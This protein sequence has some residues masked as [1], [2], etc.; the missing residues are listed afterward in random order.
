MNDKGGVAFVVMGKGHGTIT[1]TF[2]KYAKLKG[3]D[4]GLTFGVGWL[5][6]S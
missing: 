6:N 3:L 5:T 1:M 2:S 4:V